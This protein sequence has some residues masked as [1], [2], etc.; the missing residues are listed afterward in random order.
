MKNDDEK[1]VM[2]EYTGGDHRLNLDETIS[3]THIQFHPSITAVNDRAFSDCSRLREVALNEGLQKIGGKA[4][5]HCESL[6]SINLPST[7]IGIGHFAFDGCYNLRKVVLNDGLQKLGKLA[8]RCTP[9][10]E[11]EIPSTVCEIE[12]GAFVDCRSMGKVVLNEGLMQIGFQA[13]QNCTS[14]ESISIPTTV[15]NIQKGAF[16][17]CRNLT[18]ITLN[19]GLQKIETKAFEGCSSLEAVSL[20]STLTMIG[21]NAFGQCSNLRVVTLHKGL[22]GTMIEKNIFQNSSL[23]SFKFDHTS[24][25][26][27][28]IIQSGHW[29]D[30]ERKID[31]KPYVE[32]SGSELLVSAADI[33][34]SLTWWVTVKERLDP[35]IKLIKYYEMK[36][37]TSLF[38]LSL[39]KAKIDQVEDTNPRG[40]D[41]C[42]I[43]VPGPVKDLILQYLANNDDMFAGCWLLDLD[44]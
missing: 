24:A 15:T 2:F 31:N 10:R 3:I 36:E 43:E 37:V 34:M 4:F 35:V 39:W 21:R 14:L 38:E 30:I 5:Q 42:R 19:E 44:S 17:N 9:L 26:L 41:A 1:I 27:N 40:R 29:V 33:D 32:W 6:Q 11:V 18:E 25:R 7:V 23:E 20:P 16:N 12:A 22:K 13:F 8:F 28:D